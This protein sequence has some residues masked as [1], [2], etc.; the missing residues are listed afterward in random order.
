[1][2]LMAQRAV[3]CSMMPCAVSLS[4]PRLPGQM[5]DFRCQRPFLK[6]A[7]VAQAL[8]Q[9]GSDSVH[10]CMNTSA[11]SERVRLFVAACAAALASAL[12]AASPAAATLGP[13]DMLQ[14]QETLKEVWG[15]RYLCAQ[16][17]SL[18]GHTTH[19]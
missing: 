9:T 13:A 4:T 19:L 16:R 17:T 12:L 2:G 11:P 1:M 6:R 3:R 7:I 14:L 15:E 5:K 18:K 8:E 10:E